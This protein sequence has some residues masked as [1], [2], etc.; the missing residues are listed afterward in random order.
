MHA[1]EL[2]I[3]IRLVQRLISIQFPQWAC[4]P[5]A[6]IESAGTMNAIYRLG[7]EMAVRLPRVEEALKDVEKEWRWLRRL[8]SALPVPI[9]VPL[10]KGEPTDDYPWPWSVTRWLRGETPVV[11]RLTDPRALAKDLGQFVHALH[12]VDA[13]RGPSSYRG[14]HL[15]ARDAPT[16]TAIAELHGIIDRDA[17]TAAWEAALRVPAWTGP[18]VWIHADLSP[19]NVLVSGGRLAAVLDFGAVGLG[20]P[21]V[22]AIAAWNLLPEN[23]RD[24]FREALAIDDAT[25]ARARGWA[26]SIALIQLPY[27]RITNPVLADNAVHVIGTICNP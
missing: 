12:R 2:D 21:A 19:G 7:T 24:T 25:W 16:R 10:A 13:T 15:A 26:L 5:L 20:D 11:G 1:H 4:L 22:D 23:A 3:D 6:R 17:A 14:V 27:Y 9:P 18:P 8:A